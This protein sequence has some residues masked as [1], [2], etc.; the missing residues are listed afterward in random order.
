VVPDVHATRDTG[1]HNCV[2]K[3]VNRARWIKARDSTTV[4]TMALSVP[5]V[6]QSIRISSGDADM[7]VNPEIDEFTRQRFKRIIQ[8]QR[9]FVTVVIL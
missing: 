6:S 9:L 8:E 1:M 3:A 4:K 2:L 5:Y 7:V